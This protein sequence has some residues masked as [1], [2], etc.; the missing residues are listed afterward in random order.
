MEAN[1]K[2]IAP[3][4]PTLRPWLNINFEVVLALHKV[5]FV[6]Q[7]HG[8]ASFLMNTDVPAPRLRS[9]R[10]FQRVTCVADHR[11]LGS[12][13]GR[14]GWSSTVHPSKINACGQRRP[15]QQAVEMKSPS[16][17]RTGLC[18]QQRRTLKSH[19]GFIVCPCQGPGVM[20][21]AR[22]VS[23][24]LRSPVHPVLLCS[25]PFLQTL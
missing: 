22:P 19:D 9:A 24:L 8:I 2:Q 3:H 11:K 14:V 1:L 13:G 7:R 16:S 12:L 20:S 21:S 23:P 4:S 25:W 18:P 6:A 17:L 5:P 15:Q 10:S